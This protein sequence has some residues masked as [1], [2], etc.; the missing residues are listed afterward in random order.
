M[1]QIHSLKSERRLSVEDASLADGITGWVLMMTQFNKIF[2]TQIEEVLLN[3]FIT[4][5]TTDTFY[6]IDYVSQG[7][8]GIAELISANNDH[9]NGLREKLIDQLILK[10][11]KNQKYLLNPKFSDY[12]FFEGASGIIYQQL[13]LLFPDKVPSAIMLS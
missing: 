4:Q 1:P 5:L 8:L 10:F 7:T 6:K 2:N 12:S 9:V 13:R 3:N 11:N